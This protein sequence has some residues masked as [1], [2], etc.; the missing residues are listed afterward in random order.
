M[1]LLPTEGPKQAA[2]LICIVAVA[3][4]WA[5][6]DYWYNPRLAE[7]TRLE[8]RLTQLE[9]QNRRAQNLSLRGGAELEAGLALYER[10]LRRLEELIPSQSEVPVLLRSITAEAGRTGVDMGSMRPQPSQTGSFYTRDAYEMAV[11]GE[12]HNIGRF[13]EAVASLPRIMTPLDLDIQPFSG[14]VAQEMQAPV[15]ARFRLET[16]LSPRGEGQ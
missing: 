9:A 1:A 5:F 11:I 8:S 6:F 13:L 2:L 16:F 4:A 3:L 14:P 10:H 7:I 12:Y 15:L